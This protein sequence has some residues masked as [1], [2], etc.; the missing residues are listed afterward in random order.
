M[1]NHANVNEMVFSTRDTD[2]SPV[3]QFCE[4]LLMRPIMC[5]CMVHFDERGEGSDGF[6]CQANRFQ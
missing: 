3:L 4:G 6:R 1:V 5:G 2:S